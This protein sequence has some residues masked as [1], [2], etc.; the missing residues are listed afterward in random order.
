L[1]AREDAA[2][3]GSAI[4][5]GFVGVNALGGFLAAEVFFEKLLDLG[6]TSRAANKNDLEKIHPQQPFRSVV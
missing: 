1:L 5:D 6:D 4:G 2:L 3:Y